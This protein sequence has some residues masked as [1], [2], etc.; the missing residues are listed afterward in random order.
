MP[1]LEMTGINKSF[2]G[3]QVLFDVDLKLEAGEIHALL[4]ENG[5]GKSTLMNI[6]AGVYTKDSGQVIFDGQVLENLTIRQAKELG[7]AFVHQELNII[8][9]LRVYENLF[10]GK[11]E[12]GFGGALKKKEMIAKASDLFSS[13]GV[14]IDPT[15]YAGSLDMSQKQLLEIASALYAD[16]KL[17]ILDEPTT[18]LNTDEI[19]SFFELIRNAAQQGTA[20]VFISHKMPEIFALADHYSVLRDGHLIVSGKIEDT[21]PLELTN[22]MVGEMREVDNDETTKKIG[23]VV[24]EVENL[25][26]VGF[27]NVSFDVRQGEILCLTGLRG[28]GCSEVL[29][30]IFGLLPVK[31]GSIK[32]KGELLNIDSIKEAMQKGIAM[33]PSNR[34][35]NAVISCMS[36]IENTCISEH[37]LSFR[38]QHINKKEEIKRYRPL[39]KKLNIKSECAHDPITSFSG[40]NQQK[41]ILA[42]WLNTDADILLLDNPTQGI[43]VGAKSEIYRLIKEL[44]HEGKTI[45]INT[46]EIPEIQRI[47]DRLAVFYQGQIVGMLTNEEINESRVMRLATQADYRDSAINK[48]EKIS[49]KEREA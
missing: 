33:V 18:A 4:G 19:N 42:R 44:A 31:D 27:N 34:K 13:L 21:S 39:E 5:A 15:V 32:V 36:S 24:L 8:N 2:Y 14:D 26:G 43:D 16:A 12:V 23:D 11:E 22:A 25:S 48:A 49:I 3:V 40:G 1:L 17:I 30:T 28:A 20:F 45:I 41:I 7:L 35:E 10:L 37:S 47:A 6:L 9:E 29:C 38:K 46:L